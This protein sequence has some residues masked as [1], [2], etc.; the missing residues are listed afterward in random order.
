MR[1]F[2][3][4]KADRILKHS[5]FLRIS[6]CGIKLQN[7]YFVVLFC[8]GSF[9]RT[10]LGITVS[11]KVGNAVERNRIKRIFREYFRLNGY[12]ITDFWDI[13]IIAKK[14]AAGLTSDVALF[15]LQKIFDKISFVHD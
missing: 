4:T 1:F 11:K 14:E 9:K 8:P 12:R 10:R 6:R 3:F 13:N 5:D 2:P 7:R 15:F